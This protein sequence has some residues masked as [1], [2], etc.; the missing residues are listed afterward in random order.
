MQDDLGGAKQVHCFRGQQIGVTGTCAHQVDLAFHD[1]YVH[2][3]NLTSRKSRGP[4]VLREPGMAPL[5]VLLRSRLAPSR[6]VVRAEDGIAYIVTTDT[7][8]LS[9]AEYP[10]NT[11]HH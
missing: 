5:A 10:R 1:W 11:G 9:A 6:G 4:C 8:S 3:R 2:L 7:E